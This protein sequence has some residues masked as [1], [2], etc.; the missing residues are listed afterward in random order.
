MSDTTDPAATKDTVECFRKFSFRLETC[1]ILENVDFVYQID[2]AEIEPQQGI[3]PFDLTEHIPF[4]PERNAL[5]L[6]PEF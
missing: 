6:F 2:A 4:C 5:S 1:P 3:E